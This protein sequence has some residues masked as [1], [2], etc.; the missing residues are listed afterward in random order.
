M[1]IQVNVV[2]NLVETIVQLIATGILFFSV[3]KKLYEPVSK[4]LKDRQEYIEKGVRDSKE[5]EEKLQQMQ[6]EYDNKILEAKQESNF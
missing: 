5:A 1:G 6:T 3:S 2:P 4:L